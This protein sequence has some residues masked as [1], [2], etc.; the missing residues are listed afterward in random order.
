MSV[1]FDENQFK[2]PHPNMGARKRVEHLDYSYAYDEYY[3][4]LAKVYTFILKNCIS[5]VSTAMKQNSSLI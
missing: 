4:L 5:K 1:N 2:I 3:L